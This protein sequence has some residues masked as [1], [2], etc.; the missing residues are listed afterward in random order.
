MA[1]PI[2]KLQGSP[3]AG[4]SH[5]LA[6]DPTALPSLLAFYPGSVPLLAP[7]FRGEVVIEPSIM[8]IE[9]LG[10]GRENLLRSGDITLS[11]STM[12]ENFARI[13]HDALPR[14]TAW[15]CTERPCPRERQLMHADQY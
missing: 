9:V 6:H 13:R 7:L 15:P 3:L 4:A 10:R 14:P 2:R 5:A 8:M 12:I 11:A 1:N